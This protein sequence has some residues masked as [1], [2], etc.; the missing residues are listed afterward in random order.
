MQFEIRLDAF[1]C[2]GRL[3]G[4]ENGR[5]TEPT[6]HIDSVT[7]LREQDIDAID[8][9]SSLLIEHFEGMFSPDEAT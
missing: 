2:S 9:T 8:V 3:D 1:R 5:G 7:D 6:I 4:F